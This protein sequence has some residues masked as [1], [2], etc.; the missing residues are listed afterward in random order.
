[1]AAVEVVSVAGDA[2][3]LAEEQVTVS[4]AAVASAAELDAVSAA[5]Q[6]GSAAGPVSV[7]AVL[8][9]AD[10]TPAQRAAPADLAPADEVD[11]ALAD[12][13]RRDPGAG[14]R[15]VPGWAV[16]VRPA[17]AAVDPGRPD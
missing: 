14:D 12:R 5:A 16:E 7:P 9:A 15:A 1:V 11:P 3:A 17:L 6:E 8:V 13:V 2:G 4:A 10:F